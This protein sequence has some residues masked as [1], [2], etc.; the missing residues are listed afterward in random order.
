VSPAPFW[1]VFLSSTSTC[2]RR[3]GREVEL[4]LKNSSL[5]VAAAFDFSNGNAAIGLLPVFLLVVGRQETPRV[6][7]RLVVPRVL[8][9]PRLV[10]YNAGARTPSLR[11]L[12]LYLASL[13]ASAAAARSRRLLPVS[14]CGTRDGVVLAVDKGGALRS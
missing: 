14:Q 4:H 6:L 3:I 2:A 7:A 8:R 12:S 13:G 1:S 5:S 10:G 11:L 9:R